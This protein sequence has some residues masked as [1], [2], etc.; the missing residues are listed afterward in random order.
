MTAQVDR[1]VGHAADKAHVADEILLVQRTAVVCR[2]IIRMQHERHVDV[3][4]FI[5]PPGSIGDVL[6]MEAVIASVLQIRGDPVALFIQ[7]LGTELLAGI[8][9]TVAAHQQLVDHRVHDDCIILADSIRRAWTQHI[10]SI[11]LPLLIV[12]IQCHLR[13]EIA[14]ILQRLFQVFATLSGQQCVEHHRRLTHRPQGAVQPRTV[15]SCQ[16]IDAQRHLHRR[17]PAR[18]ALLPHVV[19]QCHWVDVL[20]LI[21][22]HHTDL[23]QHIGA[24]RQMSGR[25]TAAQDQRS[26]DHRQTLFQHRNFH[27]PVLIYLQ[28]YKKFRVIR[29]ISAFFCTFA[30]DNPYN[31]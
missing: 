25:R 6:F 30:Q 28:N 4:R 26:C 7:R 5:M 19:L 2:T 12:H 29:I 8:E 11:A 31:P 27:L 1:R 9:R 22:S 24:F 16:R 3:L 14:F 18:V 23:V 13:I 10:H 20:V 15:T 21:V 17:Q